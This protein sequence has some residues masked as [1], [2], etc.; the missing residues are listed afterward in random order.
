VLEYAGIVNNR[1]FVACV[2]CLDLQITP[3][4]CAA[5]NPNP[6]YLKTLLNILPEYGI[7][8]SQ[9]RRPVH[10]AAACEGTG[11]LGLLLSR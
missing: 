10:Y 3:I 5:I 11:P 7:V 8:D 9:L 6:K 4:H 2:I 1:S